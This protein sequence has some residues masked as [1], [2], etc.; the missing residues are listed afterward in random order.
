MNC[1]KH[2][3]YPNGGGGGYNEMYSFFL[4]QGQDLCFTASPSVLL[5][6]R[7]L[8]RRDVC[9]LRLS[10]V[11][12]CSGCDGADVHV[13]YQAMPYQNVVRVSN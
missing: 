5:P 13:I 7:Q 8:R 3:Q 1:Y 11:F 2:V 4:P 6:R 9:L 12:Q 10:W